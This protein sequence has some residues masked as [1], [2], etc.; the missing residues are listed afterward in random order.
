MSRG[1]TAV[2]KTYW[3]SGSGAGGDQLGCSN[4]PS[5]SSSL[6]IH[7]PNSSWL[8]RGTSTRSSAEAKNVIA[9]R[10]QAD[11]R[12]LASDGRAKECPGMCVHKL[13]GRFCT[14]Q[15]AHA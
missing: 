8:K 6:I 5:G 4:T 15:T 12:A 1:R 2:Q 11:N 14:L 7:S 10:V 13:R 9:T 3:A